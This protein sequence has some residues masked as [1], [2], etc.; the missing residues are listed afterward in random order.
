MLWRIPLTGSVA[1]SITTPGRFLVE[2]RPFE[3][4]VAKVGLFVDHSTL[5]GNA[6]WLRF[7]ANCT[8][9]FLETVTCCWVGSPWR[10]LA[11]LIEVTGFMT[12]GSWRY[13][14]VPVLTVNSV[15]SDTGRSVKPGSEP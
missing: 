1:V 5:Y 11:I 12:I 9:L 13:V 8:L 3:L 14:P 6:P 4:T 2:T 10:V 7:S 15:V